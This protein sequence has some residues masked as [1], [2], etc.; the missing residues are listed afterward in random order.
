[1]FSLP[2]QYIVVL[3]LFIAI[4]G[5]DKDNPV[6]PGDE[7]D[8]HAEAE[9]FI[10]TAADS[11]IVRYE[12]GAVTGAIEVNSGETI[13]SFAVT[14]LDENDSLFTP[15][16]VHH[17]LKI[18]VADTAKIA[19]R[20]SASDPWKFSITGIMAGETQ[21]VIK[22]FH[23]DHEDFVSLPVPVIVHSALAQ[24]EEVEKTWIEF[25]SGSSTLSTWKQSDDPIHQ[26]A[27]RF[28]D[29]EKHSTGFEA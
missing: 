5:C 18:D 1:M 29:M 6:D 28:F 24:V 8:D 23:N 3:M 15:D 9:G 7:D 16:T 11:E 17:T 25:V 20:L 12:N 27:F 14:F 26:H 22:I 10:I 19:V 13:I 2:K 21:I 4:S